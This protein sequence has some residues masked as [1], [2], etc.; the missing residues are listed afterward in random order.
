[1][2]H[3][4]ELS[5]RPSSKT[6]RPH[7]LSNFNFTSLYNNPNLNHSFP[8]ASSCSVHWDIQNFKIWPLL[9]A[10]TFTKLLNCLPRIYIGS[11]HLGYGLRSTRSSFNMGHLPVVSVCTTCSSISIKATISTCSCGQFPKTNCEAALTFALFY[12]INAVE[13]SL[14]IIAG[15]H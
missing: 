8:Y 10:H 3:C 14:V 15:N 4:Q 13:L 11:S 9:S 12:N 2:L 1:M 7:R 6:I 5:R